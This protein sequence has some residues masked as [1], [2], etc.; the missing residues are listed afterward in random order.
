MRKREKPSSL[1]GTN[2]KKRALS[3]LL[4]LVMILS[5][6]MTGCGEKT[7]E[8]AA[9][10]LAEEASVNNMTLSMWVVVDEKPSAETAAAVTAAL[11]EITEENLKT[12][13]AIT[14]LTRDEYERKLSAAIEAYQY[15]PTTK[16]SEEE[17]TE[18]TT[19]A[20]DE[21]T[22]TENKAFFE[23]I[24]PELIKNQVDVIYIDGKEMYTSY[25]AKDWL[26]PL[27]DE[28]TGSA[29]NAPLKEYMSTALYN[30]MKL[31][32]KTIYAIPNN[33]VV[34]K[35]TYMLLNKGLVDKYLGGFAGANA[36]NAFYNEYIYNY[37]DTVNQYED[38]VVL[39]DGTYDQY[40]NLMAHYWNFD[41][42]NYGLVDGFSLFGQAY[43][44]T[45]ALS[46]GQ[47]NLSYES[48][49]G[50]ESFRNAFLK[51]N[52][53]D[54]KNY[55]ED[56][57]DDTKAAM[58]L[59][60]SDRLFDTH[61][62]G[63]DFD[64]FDI[65]TYGGEDYYAV[66]VGM[67]TLTEDELFENGMFA[68]CKKS[69]SVTRSSQIITYINTN[70]E[71]R[72]T[73]LYGVKGTHYNTMERG[74]ANG[75]SYT[76][77]YRMTDDYK[78]SMAASGNMFRIYPLVDLENEE[79]SMD[80]NAWSWGKK[81]NFDAVIDPTLAFDLSKQADVN[82][83]LTDYMIALNNDLVAMMNEVKTHSDWYGEME[84]LVDE[85][86][87]LLD[88]AS[89]LEIDD[90]TVLKAYLEDEE[91]TVGGDLSKLRENLTNAASDA[92]VDKKLSP[93]GAYNAWL[94]ACNLK[95]KTATTTTPAN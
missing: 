90:F 51:L 40:L 65:A 30:A 94:S 27:Q 33:H 93:F 9:A 85:I 2:M 52:S 74:A 10:D 21:E 67:P 82:T 78:M 71:F 64:R 68:V 89:E 76:V 57:S 95:V 77:A 79:N 55:F 59:I 58:K 35:Y 20:A 41:A 66:P 80:P 72:N 31:D 86:A 54:A 6:L 62:T 44:G 81:Q 5:V 16:P 63:N 61:Y 92:R 47:V 34:G 60:V 17:N 1:G 53:F 24:Y 50:N 69:V 87:A 43:K 11:S 91:S 84:T 29:I 56:V 12:R 25:M 39:I 18:K 70:A 4:C 49:L 46:R 8:E 28:L 48:L 23:P 3:L 42:D 26:A 37:L 83:K 14:Y 32:G 7:D 36:V 38:D 22:T 13:L 15:V 73:L 75:Q 45:N 88:P 19:T